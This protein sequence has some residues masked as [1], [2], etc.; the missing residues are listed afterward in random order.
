MSE[1]AILSAAPG[2]IRADCTYTLPEFKARLRLNDDAMR[3]AKRKGLPVRRLGRRCY[4]N[5]AE[6]IE[7]LKAC[8]TV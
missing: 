3:K 6:A 4:V 2:E 1:Q 5:G 7:F 8:P